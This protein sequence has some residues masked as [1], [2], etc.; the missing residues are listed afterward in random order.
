MP[1][2]DTGGYEVIQNEGVEH[3][4]PENDG[5]HEALSTCPCEPMQARNVQGP[6]RLP[7]YLHRSLPAPL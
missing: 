6:S 2:E 4:I 7:T 5:I 1:A 3:L